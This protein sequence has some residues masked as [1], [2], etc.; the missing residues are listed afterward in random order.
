MKKSVPALFVFLIAVLS[1][2]CGHHAAPAAP[3]TASADT[4]GFF[5]LPVFFKDQ[6]AYAQS[7]HAPIYR[8]TIK[9]G[10]K[11][12][13]SLN[14]EVFKQWVDIFLSK[15]ISAPNIKGFYRESVFRDLGTKS[16]TLSYTTAHDNAIIRGIDI[17]LDEESNNVKR[18][19]I[20]SQYNRGD[21]SI[22]EQCNWKAYKSFQV[23]R[24][25]HAG[26]Y[27]ST[28]LNYVNWNNDTP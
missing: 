28:E 27:S 10:K 16:Y 13:V 17:L 22:T 5:A 1:V 6:L 21:T 12:S 20:R 9:D 25:I 3:Q 23:N 18:V 2:A 11:D 26:R 4:A 15:D 24:Y 14:Q 7:V 19:F 8:I